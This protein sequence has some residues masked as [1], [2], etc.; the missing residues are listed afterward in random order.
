MLPV[1]TALIQVGW[2]TA[3]VQIAIAVPPSHTPVVIPVRRFV[4][5]APATSAAN[6]SI[7]TAQIPTQRDSS[8]PSPLHT[9]ANPY[10]SI[11]TGSFIQAVVLLQHISRKL[12]NLSRLNVRSI[13]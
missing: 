10:T 9:V 3:T 4:R 13:I 11:Q 12:H 6:L 5:V 1:P 2:K 8:A 7:G